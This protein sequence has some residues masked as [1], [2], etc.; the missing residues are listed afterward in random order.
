ML[1]NPKLYFEIR[2]NLAK[3][4]SL[5]TKARNSK[6]ITENERPSSPLTD[7]V[8]KFL[9]K[10]IKKVPLL[11]LASIIARLPHPPDTAPERR[12]RTERSNGLDLSVNRDPYHVRTLR[13][14][15][16]ESWRESAEPDKPKPYLTP[17]RP[18][19]SNT[20]SFYPV[21]PRQYRSRATSPKQGYR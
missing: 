8:Y 21:T 19:T 11:D 6:A 3:A 5:L 10:E 17:K 13:E 16:I 9:G 1:V 4:P 2:R 7:S 20:Y 18:A 12:P 14:A 15:A